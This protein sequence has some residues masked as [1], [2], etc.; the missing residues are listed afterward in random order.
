MDRRVKN[1]RTGVHLHL[2]VADGM[3]DDKTGGYLIS[4]TCQRI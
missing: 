3:V 1:C 4:G 2:I